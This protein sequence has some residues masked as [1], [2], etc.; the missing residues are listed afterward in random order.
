MA[1]ANSNSGSQWVPLAGSMRQL[2]PQSVPIGPADL[3]ATVALTIKVRSQGNLADLDSVVRQM[4]ATPVSQ[5]TYMSRE[6]L[7]AKFG[8][9]ASD[10]DQVELYANKHHLSVAERDDA[11]RRVVLKGTLRD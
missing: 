10:L 8:A 2:L 4:S 9:S 6:D 7:A 3:N 11:T 5:R 1:D